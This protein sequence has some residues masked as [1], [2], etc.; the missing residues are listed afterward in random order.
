VRAWW[1]SPTRFSRHPFKCNPAAEVH[2]ALTAATV[3]GRAS[4]GGVERRVP[5]RDT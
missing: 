5:I 2:M 3:L 4:R 1:C